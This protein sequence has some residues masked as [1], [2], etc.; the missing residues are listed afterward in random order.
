MTLTGQ[1]T[2]LSSF[3]SHTSIFSGAEVH[4][5]SHDMLFIIQNQTSVT[6]ASYL[7]NFIISIK[8]EEYLWFVDISL[9]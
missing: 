6:H 7:S 8:N 3:Y 1:H 5:L 9:E 4:L 2:C